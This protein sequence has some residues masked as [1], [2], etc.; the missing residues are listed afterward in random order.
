MKPLSE[1]G[2]LNKLQ[3][4]Q[5]SVLRC[6]S[7]HPETQMYTHMECFR[8]WMEASAAGHSTAKVQ[9][10]YGSVPSGTARVDTIVRRSRLFTA[11]QP[12]VTKPPLGHCIMQHHIRFSWVNWS[13]WAVLGRQKHKQIQYSFS[14]TT[15]DVY[16]FH[17]HLVLITLINIFWSYELQVYL[18]TY[19]IHTVE[20]KVFS[21]IWPFYCC[22][23]VQTN[24]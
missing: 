24:L 7:A 3:S 23:S 1:G 19:I 15:G 21:L 8:G 18:F 12:P 14:C 13:S 6:S 16:V 9:S 10:Q 20:N 11:R 4:P 2:L 5:G 22:I 17:Y